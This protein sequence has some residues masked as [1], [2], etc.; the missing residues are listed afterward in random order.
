MPLER[1]LSQ[2]GVDASPVDRKGRRNVC[3]GPDVPSNSSGG[4]LE[5]RLPQKGKNPWNAE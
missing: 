2:T 5:Y 1:W 4:M 3:E